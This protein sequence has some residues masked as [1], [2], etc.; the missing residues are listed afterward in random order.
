VNFTVDT[1]KLGEMLIIMPWPVWVFLSIMP[2][3]FFLIM[4]SKAKILL[5]K[6]GNW[7]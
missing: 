3:S 1:Y 5:E 4:V 2:I 6:K 7:F